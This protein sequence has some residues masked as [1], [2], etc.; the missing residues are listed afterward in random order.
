MLIRPL[1]DHVSRELSAL[2]G[3]P[4]KVN[5]V[6]PVGGG[7]INTCYNLETT[8]GCFFIKINSASRFPGMFD[9]E[10]MGLGMLRSTNVFGIP[11]V[12]S[13]GMFGNLSYLLMEMVFAA[14]RKNN[15]FEMFGESLAA[16]H[17]NS[18]LLFGLGHDNYIGSLKQSNRQ[19][20]SGLMFMIQ[21]RYEPM[22]KLA[23]S[24][25]L[26]NKEDLKLFEALYSVLEKIFPQEKPSL[27][28]GDLWSGNF[29]TG[30]DGRA[31]LIDPAVYYGYREADLAM[32]RLFGG[33][34]QSFY[35]SY[36]N[37]YPL[38][39]GWEDRTELFQLYPLLVHLNLFGRSYKQGVI[40]CVKKYL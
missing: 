32:S 15:F 23:F 10:A 30:S 38:T 4:V 34:E 26:L 36:A 24:K 27:L 22:K 5:H 6:F 17:K 21:E 16:L 1:A 19:C 39:A 11:E 8:G 13:L 12:F 14:P 2:T 9:A 35:E 28:H 31:W 20:K 29:I 3:K 33:F 7:S 37:S 40:S 25:E 18:D